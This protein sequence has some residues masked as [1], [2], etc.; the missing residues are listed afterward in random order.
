[1][2][3]LVVGRDGNVDVLGGRVSVAKSDNGNVDVRSLLDS[4]GVGAGVSDDD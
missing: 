1:M 4:L 3:T 2:T